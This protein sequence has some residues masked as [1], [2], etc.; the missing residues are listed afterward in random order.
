MTTI[1]LT[2]EGFNAR[3]G[4]G[5]LAFD[6][7]MEITIW[8]PPTLCRLEK[9]GRVMKGWAEL[10]VES[11][12]DGARVVWREDI[13]LTGSPRLLDG[14]TRMASRKVFGKVIDGLLAGA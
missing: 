8:K 10:T 13:R 12:G 6:D 9:R 1:H 14:P 3:T 11:L 2:D 5:R 7:P 4:F